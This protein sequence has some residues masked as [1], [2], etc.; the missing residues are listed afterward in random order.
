MVNMGYETTDP[1]RTIATPAEQ[2]GELPLNDTVCG[3]PRVDQRL[4]HDG[5]CLARGTT[6]ERVERPILEARYAGARTDPRVFIEG[7]LS[8]YGLDVS[9]KGQAALDA[10]NAARDVEQSQ[11]RRVKMETD[12]D[13]LAEWLAVAGEI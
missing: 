11:I 7:I 3:C 13:A 10:F 6:T 9:L 8:H 12:H 2:E 5:R 4:V 1:S